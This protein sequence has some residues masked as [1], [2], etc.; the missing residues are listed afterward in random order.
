MN[1]HQARH[2]YIFTGN[3]YNRLLE[4]IDIL[5]ETGHPDFEIWEPHDKTRKIKLLVVE[6]DPL[7]PE[8]CMDNRIWETSPNVF[9]AFYS[10]HLEAYDVRQKYFYCTN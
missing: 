3:V 9:A 6:G 10:M 7:T 4:I 8:F 1:N 2:Y 5:N